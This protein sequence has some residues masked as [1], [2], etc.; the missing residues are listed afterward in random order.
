MR[1]KVFIFYFLQMI[2]LPLCGVYNIVEVE[3]IIKFYIIFYGL[4]VKGLM[5]PYYFYKVSILYI[6]FH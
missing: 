4:S 6:H 2:M 5:I 3:V 1:H